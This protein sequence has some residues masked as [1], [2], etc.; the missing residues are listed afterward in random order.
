MGTG[1]RQLQAAKLD[2]EKW[3]QARR[4]ALRA[5]RKAPQRMR[6]PPSFLSEALGCQESRQGTRYSRLATGTPGMGRWGGRGLGC[7]LRALLLSGVSGRRG[8]ERENPEAGLVDSE[9]ATEKKGPS[10]EPPPSLTPSL[11][12]SFERDGMAVIQ[13]KL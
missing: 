2:L 6:V 10:A 8:S 1:P 5:R 4:E 3:L 7:G 12:A 9:V 11:N 13:A